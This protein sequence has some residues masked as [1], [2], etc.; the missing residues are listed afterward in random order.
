MKN[1][2]GF[3]EQIKPGQ[4]TSTN[5]PHSVTR[6]SRLVPTG[7]S[8]LQCNKGK[9]AEMSATSA[10]KF[11]LFLLG[12]HTKFIQI[13]TSAQHIDPLPNDIQLAIFQNCVRKH[14]LEI[15][16]ASRNGDL[17]A[18]LSNSQHHNNQELSTF[19]FIYSWSNWWK[20][21]AWIHTTLQKTQD[22]FFKV[23][24][25]DIPYLKMSEWNSLLHDDT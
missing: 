11:I 2:C 18:H 12:V 5:L 19:P 4:S 22:C 1:D 25:S 14:P 16:V 24:K 21:N 6:Y 10:S 20:A 17:A 8:I 9:S 7:P 15:N 3:K 23:Q 13:C